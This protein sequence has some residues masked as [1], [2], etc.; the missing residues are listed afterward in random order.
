[1]KAGRLFAMFADKDDAEVFVDVKG[2]LLPVI[3]AEYRPGHR[4]QVVIHLDPLKVLQLLEKL[5]NAADQQGP[6]GTPDHH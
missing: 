5:K 2:E 1:M 3:A 6:Y 4:N